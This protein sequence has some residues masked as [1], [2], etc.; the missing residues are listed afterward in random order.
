VLQESIT[1]STRA[2]VVLPESTA[3]LPLPGAQAV[4]L[5]EALLE[6]QLEWFLEAGHIRKGISHGHRI[7]I[8]FY[9]NYDLISALLTSILDQDSPSLLGFPHLDDYLIF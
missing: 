7:P 1:H 5:Q 9:P 2:L 8:D 3:R 6:L 4:Q